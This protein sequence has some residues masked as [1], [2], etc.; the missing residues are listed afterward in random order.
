MIRELNEQIVDASAPAV[1]AMERLYALRKTQRNILSAIEYITNALPVVQL[2]CKAT[3]QLANRRFYPALKSLEELEVL[4]L[5]PSGMTY[6]FAETMRQRVPVLRA[7][8]KQEAFDDLQAFLTNIRDN[9]AR[10]GNSAMEH[11]VAY[12]IGGMSR[13]FL[14]IA[15]GR[16]YNLDCRTVLVTNFAHPA[17]ALSDLQ[18]IHN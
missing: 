6:T 3:S 8:V 5:K 17:V 4:Y 2:Y 13:D 12:D 7:K 1:D 14:W 18:W 11:T 15:C 9:A 16:R 10:I